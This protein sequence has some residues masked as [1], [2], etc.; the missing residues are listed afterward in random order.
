MMASAFLGFALLG[1]AQEAL[2]FNIPKVKVDFFAEAGCPFCR[3]TIA[4]PVN[5]TLSDPGLAAIMDFDFFPFG[6]AFFVTKE[7]GGSAG[8]YDVDVRQC[9]DK[10]CGSAAASAPADCFTGAPV[11]QH[12]APECNA[13]RYLACAKEVSGKESLMKFMSFTHC[14]EASYDSFSD[15]VVMTCADSIGLDK[16]KLSK[17]YSSSDGDAAVIAQAKATPIHPGV[18][19]LVVDGKA[20]DDPSTFASAVCKAYKGTKPASCPGFF[21][22]ALRYLVI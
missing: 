16:A 4:G 13:N 9:W 18:P 1:L 11:C 8:D 2:A 22:G 6:N 14:V 7:C 21:E 19:Y 3:R 5:K 20:L 12:G 17:C 15:A 10:T